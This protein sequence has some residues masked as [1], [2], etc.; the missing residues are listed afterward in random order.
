MSDDRPSST[1]LSREEV[2]RL[3]EIGKQI[4]KDVE[5]R[6]DQMERMSEIES[7]SRVKRGRTL[8]LI[9]KAF[10]S[11]YE[12]QSTSLYLTHS[13]S[14]ARECYHKASRMLTDNWY[15]TPPDQQAQELKGWVKTYPKLS[16]R[17]SNGGMVTFMMYSTST[18][19]KYSS[20]EYEKFVDHYVYEARSKGLL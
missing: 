16:F 19:S 9:R 4:R 13:W 12:T 11:A 14:F 3:L 1:P 6:F 18:R 5:K 2:R 10:F 15:N 8:G 20:P 17:H 7:P